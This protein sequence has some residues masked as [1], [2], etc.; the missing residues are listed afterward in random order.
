LIFL[1]PVLTHSTISNT[2]AD[3]QS[4]HR[5]DT[6]DKAGERTPENADDVIK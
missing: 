1:V 5:N 6:E 2:F 3:E 4:E